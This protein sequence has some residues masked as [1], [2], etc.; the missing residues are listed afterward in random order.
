MDSIQRGMVS[1]RSALPG[2][3]KESAELEADRFYKSQVGIEL[4]IFDE[5]SSLV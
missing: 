3:R 4:L 2:A 5:L 1:L